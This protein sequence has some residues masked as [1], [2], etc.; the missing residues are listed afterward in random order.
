MGQNCVTTELFRGFLDA[1]QDS[2]VDVIHPAAHAT[3]DVVM[4][5]RVA[6]ETALGSSDIH[7][8]D[9]SFV[10]QQLKIAIHGRDTDLGKLLPHNS[11][12]ILGRGVTRDLVQFFQD[13]P[14]LLGHSA[15]RFWV[16]MAMSLSL[17]GSVSN[18]MPDA[19]TCVK[20]F[21]VEKGVRIRGR[22]L[23]CEFR[24]RAG[25]VTHLEILC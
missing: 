12:E 23:K 11:V 20:N 3:P 15:W 10:G 8:P 13:H 1:C 24:G 9:H 18:K 19:L 22:V 17:L 21:L 7:F 16:H 5:C 25:G 6:V 14:T 4:I 2:H